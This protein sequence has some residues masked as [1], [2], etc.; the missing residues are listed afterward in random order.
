[1]EKGTKCRVISDDYGFFK[2]GEIV[3]ALETND[4][5][6]CAKESAYSPEKAL[7]SYKSSEYNAL[8][9]RELEVIEE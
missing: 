1:M 9:E 6:Y 2:P 5:P 8:K 7:I 3:I 4:V